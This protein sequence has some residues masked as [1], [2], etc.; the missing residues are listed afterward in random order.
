MCVLFLKF[1]YVLYF[2]SFSIGLSV[3]V[4]LLFCVTV[5]FHSFFPSFLSLLSIVFMH[6]FFVDPSLFS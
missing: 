6:V 5:F 3:V 4:L 1:C 2:F